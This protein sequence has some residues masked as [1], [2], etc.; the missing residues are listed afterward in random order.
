MGARGASEER[1]VLSLFIQTKVRGARTGRPLRKIGDGKHS[2]GVCVQPE[3]L[4][5]RDGDAHVTSIE[6]RAGGERRGK[7]R[8]S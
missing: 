6:G 4:D 2:T 7:T 3:Q 8:V 5:G 1:R